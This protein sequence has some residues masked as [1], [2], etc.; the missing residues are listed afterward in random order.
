MILKTAWRARR[1]ARLA[2]PGGDLSQPGRRPRQAVTDQSVRYLEA[3]G[4]RL[5]MYMQCGAK[6]EAQ[7][8][9]SC[10]VSRVES[11]RFKELVSSRPL[12]TTSAGWLRLLALFLFLERGRR[13]SHH[14]TGRLTLSLLI[15][16]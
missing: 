16:S 8:P 15:E 12:F 5:S 2:G 13:S 11:A 6:P 4:V 1:A 14:E 9:D 7:V 10:S 3:L